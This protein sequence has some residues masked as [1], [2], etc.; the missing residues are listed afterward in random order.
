MYISP[1][2]L[3]V[4]NIKSM[5]LFR[6]LNYFMFNCVESFRNFSTVISKENN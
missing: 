3:C 5:N 4:Y 6:L 1:I 2:V